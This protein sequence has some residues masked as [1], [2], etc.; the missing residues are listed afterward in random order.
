MRRNR[1]RMEIALA[2][3]APGAHGRGARSKG[4]SYTTDRLCALVLRGI[5][6]GARANGTCLHDLEVLAQGGQAGA[7][8]RGGVVHPVEVVP[9]HA[10]RPWR[11]SRIRV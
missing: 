11:R 6:P 9:A 10:M 8:G 1:D 7:G 4:V 5:G 3:S 2:C